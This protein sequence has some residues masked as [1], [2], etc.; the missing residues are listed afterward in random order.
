M[1][2]TKLL[3]SDELNIEFII[4]DKFDIKILQV[5]PIVFKSCIITRDYNY[6]TKSISTLKNN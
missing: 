4:T 5:R 2:D 6:V 3:H 1:G